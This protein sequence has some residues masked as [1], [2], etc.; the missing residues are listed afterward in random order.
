MK[1]RSYLEF[2]AHLKGVEGHRVRSETGRVMELCGLGEVTDRTI[3]KISKGYQQRVGIAQAILNDP[4]LLIL[5][6]PTLGLDPKQIIEIRQLIKNLGGDRT[7]ILSSHILPE[8][9]QVCNRIIVINRGE[10]VAVDTPD[11]LRARLKKSAMI[12][13]KL[14]AGKGARSAR[15]AISGIDGVLLVKEKAASEGLL[16]YTIETV[17]DRDLREEITRQLVAKHLPLLEIYGEELS[18]EDI[19]LQ[20]V[21]E[22]VS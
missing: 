6:E 1:V 17:P 14:R 10:L 12:Q 11:N 15:E 18:L 8:V 20:L 5:D 3:G 19:F 9:S 13:V 22:E 4:E 2:V 16:S 7:V 21:T